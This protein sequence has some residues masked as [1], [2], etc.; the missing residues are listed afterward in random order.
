MPPP[1]PQVLEL[2]PDEPAAP[3]AEEASEKSL[4][5]EVDLSKEWA[6]LSESGSAV[7]AP[8]NADRTAEEI[9]FYLQAG[10]NAEAGAALARLQET[11]PEHS[12]IA[13][14]RDRLAPYSAAP[15]PATE[16][17]PQPSAQPVSSLPPE[18]EA[19]RPWDVSAAGELTEIVPMEQMA[20]DPAPEMVVPSMVLPPTPDR[21]VPPP[22]PVA[23]SPTQDFSLDEV[24]QPGRP[25]AAA[26]PL[27]LSLEEALPPVAPTQAV[28]PA[29]FEAAS[30]VGAS[31]QPVPSHAASNSTNSI[32]SAAPPAG[33]LDDLFA[34]FKQDVGE[35][36]ADQDIET[37]YN[38]GVA[39][40]EM[41]L[42]DEA[43]GEFQKVHQLAETS[44]DYSHIV[45]CC[46]LLATCF[47]EKGMPQLAVKW[48]QTALDSP[49][50]DSESSVALLYEVAS[51]YEMA[52]DR[53]AALKR[54][55]E[56]YAR[57]IDYRNVAERIRELQQSS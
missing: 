24:F 49:G 42:Y 38:M 32:N 55:L 36:A 14:F 57:N 47:L 4:V 45:Q 44:K 18:P 28:P 34:E 53:P 27:E 26:S 5:R 46:S 33:F 35:P 25:A 1:V 7:S 41:A 17:L 31:A 15:E 21:T 23:A 10:M 3:V 50:V 51:A 29:A 56:V 9:E 11:F 43:I 52:G 39:F 2:I 54:F 37:H 30:L 6:S 13:G 40:K 8:V 16:V 12:S 48:Y 22:E 19:V 20:A